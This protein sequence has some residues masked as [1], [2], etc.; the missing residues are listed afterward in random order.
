MTRDLIVPMPRENNTVSLAMD[1]R[2]HIRPSQVAS[3]QFTLPSKGTTL[4]LTEGYIGVG[5]DALM[6]I[7]LPSRNH[8]WL[9]AT[10]VKT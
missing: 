7:Q 9:L 10:L 1:S 4:R 8:Q 5:P 6:P 3:S 2:Y